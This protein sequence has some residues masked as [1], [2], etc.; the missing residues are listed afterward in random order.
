MRSLD[1]AARPKAALAAVFT[2]LALVVAAPAS[3][4][5]FEDALA[6]TRQ[7]DYEQ[8]LTLLRPLAQRGH[9]DQP[10]QWDR[11]QWDVE[12]RAGFVV[13]TNLLSDQLQGASASADAINMYENDFTLA[14][15][16]GNATVGLAPYLS[17]YLG[18]MALYGIGTPVDEAVAEQ[19]LEYAAQHVNGPDAESAKELLCEEFLDV[20]YC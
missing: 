13:A 1:F 16:I 6:A 15:Q 12:A 14:F 7:G 8:A 5:P 4:G 9:A 2:A 19:W 11:T 17:F 10:D 18:K 3:A 20:R